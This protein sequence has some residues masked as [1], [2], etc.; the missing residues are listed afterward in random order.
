MQPF[1]L[2]VDDKFLAKQVLQAADRVFPI[3]A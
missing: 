3:V 1:F 2:S